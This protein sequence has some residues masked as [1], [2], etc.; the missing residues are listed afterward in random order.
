[1]TIENQTEI[2]RKAKLKALKNYQLSENFN[3]LKG[4]I[5]A[6][7][8][9]AKATV[10]TAYLSLNE[11]GEIFTEEKL[12]N[13]KN[14]FAWGIEQM[15]DIKEIIDESEGGK[16]IKERLQEGIDNSEEHI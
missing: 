11:D 2:E 3:A 14:K 6:I 5:E 12:Y 16:I 15:T 1:M 7:G 8:N 4:E 9:K 13:H 10:V